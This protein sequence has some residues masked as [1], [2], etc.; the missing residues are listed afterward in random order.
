MSKETNPNG[1][2][3]TQSSYEVIRFKITE[4]FE[5]SGD[6]DYSCVKIN[7]GDISYGSNRRGIKSVKK[8]DIGEE[9]SV[10]HIIYNP[11]AKDLYV[12]TFEYDWYASKKNVSVD[13]M[14]LYPRM[15]LSRDWY[16]GFK[17][18]S[19][20]FSRLGFIDIK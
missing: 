9:H 10:S 8:G 3:E 15:K 18:R 4:R 11:T 20:R 6:S 5:S 13:H 1:R 7:D 2:V 16:Q 19:G 17:A 12:V 14:V